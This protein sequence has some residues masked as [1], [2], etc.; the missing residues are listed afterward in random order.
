MERKNV[1]TKVEEV[2]D[3]ITWRATQRRTQPKST[4]F[5]GVNPF[6][7]LWQNGKKKCDYYRYHVCQSVR[8]KTTRLQLDGFK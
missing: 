4:A 2:T 1:H 5:R 3:E 8:I 7:A 6:E